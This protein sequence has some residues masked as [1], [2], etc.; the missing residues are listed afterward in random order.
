MSIVIERQRNGKT[1]RFVHSAKDVE[2][3]DGFSE[4]RNGVVQIFFR[5]WNW[6]GILPNDS[7]NFYAS[8]TDGSLCKAEKILKK[9]ESY[10]MRLSFDLSFD[11]LECTILLDALYSN[12]S[13]SFKQIQSYSK[14]VNSILIPRY[15]FNQDLYETASY[16]VYGEIHFGNCRGI[17]M[18]LYQ[19][20]FNYFNLVRS[21]FCMFRV[22]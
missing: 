1:K 8:R 20:Y 19:E 2:L 4:P 15:G 12:I 17:L 16:F 21:A 9:E 3:S 5:P 22:P 11:G 18:S 14:L 6:N 10:N 7:F 13:V